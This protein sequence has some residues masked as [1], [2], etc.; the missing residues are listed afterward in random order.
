MIL[1]IQMKI[2]RKRG[3]LM[4]EMNN[5]RNEDS[6]STNNTFAQVKP[7]TTGLTV[8]C[9]NEVNLQDESMN[10]IGLLLVKLM[11]CNST[12]FFILLVFHS[13]FLSNY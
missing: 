6:I 13:S 4:K 11:F 5:E 9:G 10:K 2:N 8:L 1:V 3:C 12:Y 7:W